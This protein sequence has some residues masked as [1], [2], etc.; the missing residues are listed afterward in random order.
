MQV[1]CKVLLLFAGPH[2]RRG[3]LAGSCRQFGM[4]AFEFDI[5]REGEVIDMDL[6]DDRW[7]A[8]LLEEAANGFYGAAIIAIPCGSFSVA[9]LGRRGKGPTQLRARSEPDG[10]EGLDAVERAQVTRADELAKRACCIAR[11]VRRAGGQLIFENPVDRGDKESPFYRDIWGE[12]FPLWL[13]PCM[14][15]L[16]LELG[17]KSVDFPMCAF[18]SPY[19]KLTTLWYTAELDEHMRPFRDASCTCEFHEATAYGLGANGQYRSA[20]AAAYPESMNWLLASAVAAV[21]M[22]AGH[23]R[24]PL[25]I[26]SA[27]PH[28]NAALAS[29]AATLARTASSA[30]ARRLEPE[31]AA[32]LRDERLPSGNEV[33]AVTP[34]EEAPAQPEGPMP[35]PLRTCELIPAVLL[36]KV[37]DF[38]L[39]LKRCGDAAA[40]GRWQYARSARPEALYAA[41]A[42]AVLPAGLGWSWQRGRGYQSSDMWY[43]IWPSSWPLDPPST[44]L[45]LRAIVE[46]ARAESYPDMQI[47]AWMAHGFPGPC[48]LERHLLLG[49]FHVGALREY[50]AYRKCDAKD[51]SKGFVSAGEDLPPIWPAITDPTNLVM[52]RQGKARMTVDKTIEQVADQPSYNSAVQSDEQL[53]AVRVKM[54]TVGQLARGHAV[55]LQSGADVVNAGFDLEAYFR[56]IG[57]QRADWWQSC[58]AR[59]DGFGR[60]P[61]I[62]FGMREAMDTTGRSTCFLT[63]AMRL[64]LER[65]DAAYPPT[66]ASIVEW[67]DGRLRAAEREGAKPGTREWQ[68]W[69]ALALVLMFV[70]D[71]G[72][73]II[74]DELTDHRG[75]PV[76]EIVAETSEVITRVR[77]RRGAM[78]YE[79]MLG[80]IRGFGH[81]DAPGKH[82]WP[83]EVLTFLGVTLER[84][85]GV[86][87]LAK[88]KR[89]MYTADVV[90]L[91]TSSTTASGA[92]VVDFDELNSTVH[93]LLHAASVIV[94]GRQHLYYVRQA[95]HASNRMRGD[96]CVLQARARA[97]LG[98][99][100]RQL[101]ASESEGVPFASRSIFP[102][103]TCEELLVVYSDASREQ[104]T[105]EAESGWGGWSIID[106]S[107]YFVE[108]RWTL[109]EIERFS[110]NVLELHALTIATLTCIQAA[111]ELGVPITHVLEFTDNV[112]A[113]MAADRGSPHAE[114]MTLIIRG[115]GDAL[116]GLGVYTATVRI[117]TDDNDLADGLSRG[118]AHLAEAMRL[119]AASGL[120]V[121]R[122]LVADSVRAI[123]E[124]Q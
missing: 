46:F 96:K 26:G 10:K 56:K 69:C 39:A 80:V 51:R 83:G 73:S 88:E 119:A 40:R 60:D 34:W 99:W 105:R 13:L 114:L 122:L 85:R 118:G 6:L 48:T 84:H 62:Q 1:K 45:N 111:G 82:T 106:N 72:A 38:R 75:D 5:L 24:R 17:L 102:G 87:T 42:D 9:R 63:F 49:S 71:A 64:E 31:Q 103:P 95:L 36:G 76:Y 107:L 77:R 116:G 14:L 37:R 7:F 117:A 15:A 101:S 18:G 123:P 104:G 100:Q 90:A 29:E 68:R 67:R 35:A 23:V 27:K 66:E 33:P 20:A 30:S 58:I 78:Y 110:I 12:H 61:R 109:D 54:V 59:E 19:Q 124:P 57:R 70:D 98:W 43:P 81:V 91:L 53:R 94:L 32:V 74:N 50:E 41:E 44:D 113:E 16:R 97:E 11:A 47:V 25:F 2:R 79:A 108:G 115:R 89:V 55:L 28:A 8:R 52:S 121:R 92:V 112:A 93:R 21:R 4:K 3:S 65:L 120:P 86:L 22:A